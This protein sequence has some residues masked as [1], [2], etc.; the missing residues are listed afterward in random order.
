M[1]TIYLFIICTLIFEVKTLVFIPKIQMIEKFRTLTHRVLNNESYNPYVDLNTPEIIQK[2]GYPSEAHTISTEDGYLLT[3][4]RISGKFKSHPILLQHGLLASSTDWVLTGPRKSLAFI[5]ADYGYDVW[6][7]NFRGN[8][9]SRAHKNLSTNDAKFWDFSWH[10][11][12]IY[13]LP[14]MISYITNLKKSNLTYIGHSMGTTAFY[15]MSTLRSDIASRVQMMFSLAPVAYMEHIKSP[16]RLL[17]PFAH[18]LKSIIHI[19]G[20]DEFLPHNKLIEYFAKYG[21]DIDNLEHEICSNIIFAFSGFDKSQFNY[22][23][24]PVIFGHVP[25]GASVKTVVHY[26]QEIQSGKFQQFDYGLEQNLKIYNS[27]EPPNY[28][29]SK[30]SVPII[31]YY[32]NNDWCA[33][34]KDVQRLSSELNNVIDLYKIP[35]TQFNHVDFLWAIQAPKLVY[36]KILRAM[37]GS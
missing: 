2:E 22:S 19:L 24:I 1:K 32:A 17:A 11:M 29:T 21:C 16:L 26:A 13:D 12:G 25:A 7:G 35:Y 34:V 20:K 8:T 5:L 10:E 30:I 15:V 14:A 6:L 18:D 37:K 33:S 4:H 31:L 23:L 36:S 28:D 9:Y 3:L 27:V